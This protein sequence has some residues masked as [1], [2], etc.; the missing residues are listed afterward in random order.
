MQG[1]IIFLNGVSSAG[2]TT[3]S[4]TLQHKLVTPYY[5]LSEDVFRDMTPEKFDNED[6]DENELIWLNAVFGMYHTAKMYSDL[7]MNT[8]VDTVIDHTPFLDKTVEL[9]HDYPVLFV[10]VTCPLEEL[11]RREKERGDRE[12]GLAE[13]LLALLC[14]LDNTY[15]ITVDTHNNT[16]EECADKI[17]ELLDCPER[18]SAFKTLWTRRAK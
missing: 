14:P 13:E 18:F 15:D 16:Y 2:K 11:Q 17:M 7:G 9:L 10:H 12:I 5:W 3:L 6:N 8:I 1:K 4:K